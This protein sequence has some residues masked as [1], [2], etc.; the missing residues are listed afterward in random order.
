MPERQLLKSPVTENV[1]AM[2]LSVSQAF[3]RTNIASHAESSERWIEQLLE[4]SVFLFLIVPSMA[5]SFFVIKQG[6]LSF[7]ITAVATILRDLALVSLTLFFLWRNGESLKCIGWVFRNAGREGILGLALFIPM[8]V[9]AG[10]L[11]GALRAAGLSAPLTPRPAFLPTSSGNELILAFMLVV[12]V[13]VAEETIFRGY[14]MLRLK[15]ISGSDVL[16]A[17]LSAIIFSLGHGYEGAAGVITVGMMG[18]IFAL[19][20]L[21]RKSLVAPMVMHFLQDFIGIV[22]VPLLQTK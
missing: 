6:H 17:V 12:V 19:V 2:R 22:L 21:W 14:L 11:D 8:S 13:A 15:A 20:Y 1:A 3:M 10:W 18:L 4:V 5:L 9:A 16:A 7:V